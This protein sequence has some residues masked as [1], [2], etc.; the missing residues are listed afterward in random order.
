MRIRRAVLCGACC[1]MLAGCQ[2]ELNL[3][4]QPTLDPCWRNI[5][6]QGE[7]TAVGHFACADKDLVISYDIGVLAGKYASTK[8]KNRRWIRSGHLAGS[9]FRYLLDNDGTLYVTFSNE[10]PANYWA[11]VRDQDDID[12]VLELL[13]RHRKELLAR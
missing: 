3:S 4:K 13:A 10:G 12:Y 5:H 7:D 9:S 8:H 1:M 6:V 11:K 2:S